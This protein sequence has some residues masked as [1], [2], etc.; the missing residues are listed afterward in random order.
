MLEREW[1]RSQHIYVPL[2]LILLY[3]EVSFFCLKIKILVTT[4]PIGFYVLWKLLIGTVMVLGYFDFR[5]KSLAG[6]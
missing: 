6:F 5:F 2:L 4:E 3:I 1:L